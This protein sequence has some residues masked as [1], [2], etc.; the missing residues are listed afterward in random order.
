MVLSSAR[1]LQN[2][3]EGSRVRFSPRHIGVSIQFILFA[4]NNEDDIYKEV[5]KN[6]EEDK[7]N[8]E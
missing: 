3:G 2:T 4:I 1:P 7:D 5:P 6:D 8:K